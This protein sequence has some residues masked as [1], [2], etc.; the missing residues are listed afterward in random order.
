MVNNTSAGVWLLASTSPTLPLPLVPPTSPVC[1]VTLQ[2]MPP[3]E[4]L[5]ALGAGEGTV[6]AVGDEVAREVAC[7]RKGPGTVGAFDGL[8]TCPS[9]W[10][11]IICGGMNVHMH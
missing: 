10:L 3:C 4:G 7:V 11:V 2:M 8:L 1:D 6:T 5:T 9:L